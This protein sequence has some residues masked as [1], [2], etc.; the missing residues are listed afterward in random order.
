MLLIP[1]GL[2]LGTGDHATKVSC[3]RLLS[4]VSVDLKPEKWE[5]L[6]VGCGT[7]IL[8]IAGR[9][10][11]A[12][13][14]LACDFDPQAVKVTKE[15]VQR[16]AITRV[17]ARRIDVRVWR[18]ERSWDVVTANIYSELLIEVAEVLAAATAAGG[19]LIF[20]GVLREQ[21]KGVVTVIRRAG[22]GIERVVRRGK[23]I[24]GLARRLSD[25]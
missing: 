7:G 6:D 14:V 19:M 1:A 13:R 17:N 9:V 18:P 10:L 4:D 15:N 21:E 16:N 23:W 25:R 11:A 2:P 24:A 3:L 12:R 5:M 20:S 22:F 8:A